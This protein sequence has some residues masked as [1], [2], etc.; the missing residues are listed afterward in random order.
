VC[1]NVNILETILNYSFSSLQEESSITARSSITEDH[2]SES[3]CFSTDY[4]PGVN[5]G[6]GYVESSSCAYIG[7]RE[8]SNKHIGDSGVFE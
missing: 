2:L 4:A 7:E 6:E 8:E 5:M 1:S 3:D